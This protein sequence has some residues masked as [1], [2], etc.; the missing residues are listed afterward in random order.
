MD[1]RFVWSERGP[2]SLWMGIQWY[3]VCLRRSKAE[4]TLMLGFPGA[5]SVTYSSNRVFVQITVS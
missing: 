1:Q 5:F 3:S 2:S 4:A